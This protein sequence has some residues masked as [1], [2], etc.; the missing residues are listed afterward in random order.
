MRFSYIFYSSSL[1]IFASVLHFGKLALPLSLTSSSLAL[2]AV[3]LPLP[4]TLWQFIAQRFASCTSNATSQLAPL[5][6]HWFAVDARAPPHH[7][8]LQQRGLL[9][10]SHAE[11]FVSRFTDCVHPHHRGLVLGKNNRISEIV[12]CFPVW[13]VG[14]FATAVRQW[15]PTPLC[16]LR[17]GVIRWVVRHRWVVIDLRVSL[18][19]GFSD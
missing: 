9:S 7:C 8:S 4:S 2:L 13:S 11:M 16:G 5:R 10:L 3:M 1:K 17:H 15:S 6:D 18:S 19:S 14:Y 12:A